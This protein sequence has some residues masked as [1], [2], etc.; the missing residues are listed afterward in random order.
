[1]G[2]VLEASTQAAEKVK[3]LQKI[4]YRFFDDC[5]SRFWA[6]LSTVSPNTP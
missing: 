4:Q 6:F 5:L 1:V 2:L 3:Q